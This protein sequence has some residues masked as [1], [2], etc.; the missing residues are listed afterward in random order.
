MSDTPDRAAR[1]IDNGLVLGFDFGARRIGV[2]VGEA[3]VHGC[4]PLTTVHCSRHAPDWLTITRL[5]DVW[6]PA[7]LIVGL[8]LDRD[9]SSQQMTW[10]ARRFGRQ[11][12]GRFR[13]P[14]FW[15]DERWS[16]LEAESR[17]RSTAGQP[18]CGGADKDSLAAMII[19]EDW[20]ARHVQT[21]QERSLAIDRH[22]S[23]DR[24][25]TGCAG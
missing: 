5:I 20:L 14:V 17:L 7:C 1:Y 8:P 19:L 3:I 2:A 25:S 23:T 11:L 24:N 18:I 12:H 13:L 21:T 15:Q 6:R 22:E 10:R 4:R 16:S 9:G